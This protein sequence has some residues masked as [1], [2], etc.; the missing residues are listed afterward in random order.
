LLIAL[1]PAMHRWIVGP[2]PTPTPTPPPTPP[3]PVTRAEWIEHANRACEAALDGSRLIEVIGGLQAKLAA[4]NEAH[5]PGRPVPIMPASL[6]D[7]LVYVD[8]R[9]ALLD[10]R[11]DEKGV[12]PD[13]DLRAWAAD[14]DR[15]SRSMHEVGDRVKAQP[16]SEVDRQRMITS[17]VEWDSAF[18]GHITKGRTLRLMC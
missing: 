1:G 11:L 5:R 4:W 8:E 18:E 2:T 15:A 6:V 14:I 13:E 12:A 9:Y 16:I 10:A 17:L 3:T 7:D